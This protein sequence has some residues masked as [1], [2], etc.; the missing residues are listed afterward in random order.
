M[1]SQFAKLLLLCTLFFLISCEPPAATPSVY[2]VTISTGNMEERYIQK[3]FTVDN[4]LS[5]TP[6]DTSY[7][8][9]QVLSESFTKELTLGLGGLAEAEIP[10]VAKAAIN[11]N[12]TD[13]FSS[14][15]KI[16]LE[17]SQAVNFSVPEKDSQ[18]VTVFLKETLRTGEVSYTL[19][20]ETHT[21]GFGYR[22]NLEY[23]GLQKQSLPCPAP[24]GESPSPIPLPTLVPTVLPT[25]TAMPPCGDGFDMS[26]WTPVTTNQN[27]MSA[28]NGVCWQL[29]GFGMSM[30]DGTIS[31]LENHW[32]PTASW[33]GVTRPIQP[34]AKI[35]L[36]VNLQK[37][38]SGQIWIGFTDFPDNINSGKFLVIKPVAK[39]RTSYL[40]AFSI[41][42]MYGGQRYS[43]FDNVFVPFDT[44]DYKI[45]LEFDGKHL[46][47]WLNN[48]ATRAFPPFE[49]TQP[50]FFIGY[51][52]STGLDIDATISNIQIQP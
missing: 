9:G 12:I 40:S 20:G 3:E 1:R 10:A 30:F 37:L 22:I 17:T 50:Y 46:S 11:M 6:L 21:T 24:S 5:A 52:S 33:Y 34:N 15:K 41:E 16:V 42:G 39:T 29:G 45:N 2:D 43:I 48:G 8:F 25:L 14:E 28:N 47:I 38:T 44:G 49:V 18:K 7:T 26:V 4:C 51:L 36:E 23:A 27:N 31:I 35:R 13:Q 32:N 19:N